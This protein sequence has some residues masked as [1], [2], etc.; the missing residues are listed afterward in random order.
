METRL[1]VLRDAHPTRH[2]GSALLRTRPDPRAD[3]IR[4]FLL[5]PAASR[6]PAWPPWRPRPTPSR[7]R[8][9]VVHDGADVMEELRGIDAIEHAS[10]GRDVVAGIY[11]GTVPPHL[12]IILRAAKNGDGRVEIDCVQA[13]GPMMA[14]IR[15]MDRRSNDIEV[16][17]AA[18]ER[19]PEL[20][21]GSRIKFAQYPVRR[22]PSS[23]SFAPCRQRHGKRRGAAWRIGPN[24]A[25]PP[26]R[27]KNRAGE[28]DDG[29][30]AD[31][32]FI[33]HCEAG[34]AIARNRP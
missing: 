17:P 16:R 13:I 18:V 28:P 30:N 27:P 6:F 14:T 24:P 31:M 26:R 25:L 1:A 2:A 22:A 9:V 5:A 19:R 3:M 15:F 32:R 11:P 10:P 34:F 21:A 7:H 8:A 4:R 29:S 23:R 12:R 33:R 20:S